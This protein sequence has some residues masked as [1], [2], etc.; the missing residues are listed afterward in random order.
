M[1]A[2]SET[3]SLGRRFYSALV[4]AGLVT[5]L[6]HE[7]AHWIA[8]R[9]VGLDVAFRLNGVT[10]TGA[11]TQGQLLA[12]SAAGPAITYAQALLAYFFVRRESS[13]VAFAFL[14]WPAFMRV[15]AT[16]VSFILP[17]DEARVGMVLG[18]GFWTIPIVASGALCWL[19]WSG[20]RAFKIRARDFGAL[21]LIL[22]AVTAAIVFGD[23]YLL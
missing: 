15:V 6:V 12:M 2:P 17:N 3:T 7:G 14:L 20:G 16:G 13:T 9:A 11:A 1:A 22:S 18:A 4:A 21:Y 19:A 23:R 5:Y 10:P 8:G